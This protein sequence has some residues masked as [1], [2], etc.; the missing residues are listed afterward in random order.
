M[1]PATA[2]AARLASC[3]EDKKISHSNDRKIM[4]FRLYAFFLPRNI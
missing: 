2:G 1:F 4:L 3:R